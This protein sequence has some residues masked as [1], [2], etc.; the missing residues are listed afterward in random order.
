MRFDLTVNEFTRDLWAGKQA[1]RLRRAVLAPLHP[2]ARRRARRRAGAGQPGREGLRPGLQRRPLRRELPQARPGG[3]HHRAPRPR[4][5]GV[6]EARR[7][8]A[9]LQGLVREDP[10]A[11]GL[12]ARR[13]G[14]PT[15]SPRSPGRSRRSASA[16]RTTAA[17]PTS[18]M[19]DGDRL[20]PL[21]DV[22]LA[23]HEVEAVAETLRSGW[24]TMGPRIKELEEAVRRAAGRQARDRHVQL[25]LRAAPGLPGRRSGPRRRGHRP[26]HHLRGQRR[27]RPLLRRHARAGRHQGPARPGHRPRRRGVAH[28][29]RAPRP[30]ARST[31]R[32]TTP[33]W[34]ALRALCDRRGIALIEDSA[35]HPIA[36]VRSL[37]ACYSFFSNKVLSC[38]EGGLLATDDDALADAGPQPALA[39]DDHRHLGSPPRPRRRIRRRGPRLQLPH[40][41]AAGRLAHRPPRRASR[42]TSPGDAGSCAAT[43]SC[44]PARTA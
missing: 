33:T 41:R 35:H 14:S 5:R 11:A 24:L 43:A 1:R 37:A 10:R 13:T 44:W 27:G 8:P 23:D 25:H 34:S 21:F 18:D 22:R 28:H 40:G 20:I 17:T 6:R 2:R 29:R 16:T 4:R 39:R 12:P 3:D 38:G 36:P 42:T 32:A 7:G 9:R 30:S 19:A 31:T 26:G 15:A